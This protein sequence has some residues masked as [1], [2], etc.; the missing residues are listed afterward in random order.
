MNKQANLDKIRESRM[1]ELDTLK[2]IENKFIE[3]AYIIANQPLT[4]DALNNFFAVATNFV[5]F[6]QQVDQALE[7]I[8]CLESQLEK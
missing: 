1:N 8:D 4:T 5:N 7:K 3:A 6:E 2:E